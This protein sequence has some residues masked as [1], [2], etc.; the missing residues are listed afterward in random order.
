MSMVD[1]KIINREILSE[2]KYKLELIEV[3][4]S[5]SGKTEKQQREVYFRPSATAILLCDPERKTVL[6]TRQFRLPVHLSSKKP[7]MIIEVCAGV[8]DDGEFPEHA[9]VREVEEETGYRISEIKQVA[10]GF[11]SPAS[12]MEY[13]YFFT[14]IYSPD[15]RINEG[16][17]KKEE[18]EDIELIEISFTEARKMLEAGEIRDVKTILLLQHALLSGML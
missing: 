7:E 4:K 9:I 6:L 10:E 11:T 1:I 8:I 3:E 14:G 16:G 18:G 2:K 13:V 12:F 5:E 15:M 17:G